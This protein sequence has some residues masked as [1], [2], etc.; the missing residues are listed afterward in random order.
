MSDIALIW[1]S[2]EGG[3]DF[4]IERNDLATDDTFET[5]VLLSLFTDR[6]V[7]DSETLP[8]EAG[9]DRGGWWADALSPVEG[10]KLGSRLWLLRR[11][12]QEAR[13]LELAKLYATEALTWML[14]D[15][16]ADRV[17][18]TAEVHGTGALLLGVT[19]HRPGVD[20]LSYRYDY[21][22]AAQALRRA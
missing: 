15:R 2:L 20:P 7:E 16:I 21:S 4:A 3:A 22:W 8:E 13:V 5:A 1:N 19:I 11:E 12:K 10:D 6:R 18:V 9:A 14:V 17:T